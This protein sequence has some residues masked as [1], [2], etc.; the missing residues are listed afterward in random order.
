MFLIL[1]CDGKTAIYG[2]FYFPRRISLDLPSPS[3]LLSR[4]QALTRYRLPDY[5]RDPGISTALAI[6]VAAASA[7]AAL[8]A[9]TVTSQLSLANDFCHAFH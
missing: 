6:N 7:I 1:G 9:R 5:R 2:F 3:G 8:W 4:Y